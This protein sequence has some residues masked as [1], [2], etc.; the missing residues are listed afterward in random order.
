MDRDESPERKPHSE[1]NT[2]NIVQAHRALKK[3]QKRQFNA[4]ME[5]SKSGD[6]DKD[7]LADKFVTICASGN[8]QDLENF[9]A[10]NE[11]W[12]VKRCV[13]YGGDRALRLAAKNGHLQIVKHL[14]EDHKANIHAKSDIHDGSALD[15]RQDG[16]IDSAALNNDIPMLEYLLAKH[17]TP[18]CTET[19]QRRFVGLF[20]NL[21]NKGHMEAIRCLYRFGQRA[22]SPAI[23][24]QR[25]RSLESCRFIVE[26]VIELD[27]E[28]WRL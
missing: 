15:A 1:S 8:L 16:A 6:Y 28:D 9:V 20:G 25:Q 24:Y 13:H 3:L 5:F 17:S 18:M 27:E 22:E 14:V 10:Q 12:A 21:A 23:Y 26:E 4:L 19:N 2:S 7:E 11:W